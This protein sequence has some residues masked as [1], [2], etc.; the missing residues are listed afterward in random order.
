[1]TVELS[2]PIEHDAKHDV[3]V[4]IQGLPPYAVFCSGMFV[5]FK[6]SEQEVAQ[7][8]DELSEWLQTK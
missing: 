2:Q 5:A 4:V 8:R 7:L 3:E 1:M 6:L